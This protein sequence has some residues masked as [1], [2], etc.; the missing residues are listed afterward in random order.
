MRLVAQHLIDAG[1]KALAMKF[2]PDR[3]GS[4]DAMVLLTAARDGLK[5]ENALHEP[6]LCPGR[7]R[8]RVD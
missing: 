4:S 7:R 6:A 5:H 1:Y 3:G 2:H 8:M